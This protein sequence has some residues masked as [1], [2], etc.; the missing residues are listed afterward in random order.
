M[1]YDF[2]RLN[3]DPRIPIPGSPVGPLSAFHMQLADG[4]SI[5]QLLTPLVDEKGEAKPAPC[6]QVGDNT[7]AINA[8]DPSLAAAM[9][10]VDERRRS[11]P[12]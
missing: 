3:R 6:A 12:F 1:I 11:D 9:E 2:G 4:S 8:A 7:A 10:A 5:S